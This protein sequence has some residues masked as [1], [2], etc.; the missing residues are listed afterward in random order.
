M[1]TGLSPGRA[2]K[3]RKA[4]L[5]SSPDDSSPPSPSLAAEATRGGA[6][7]RGCPNPPAG[8]GCVTRGPDP[9]A[10]P[11]SP[12]RSPH[13]GGTARRGALARQRV[14]AQP[15]AQAQASKDRP[16]Q[17]HPERKLT[18]SA[19]SFTIVPSMRCFRTTAARV[20]C[21]LVMHQENRC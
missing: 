12:T 17:C 9:S 18:T 16:C 13:E 20:S 8:K 21:S 6:I 15:Q 2:L 4:L 3:R 11:P 1:N 10:A 5:A 7:P 14:P 19:L